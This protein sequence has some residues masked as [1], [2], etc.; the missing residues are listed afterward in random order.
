[1]RQ[2]IEA[3]VTS[4]ET[5]GMTRRQLVGNLAALVGL[6][7]GGAGGLLAQSPAEKSTF[8]AFGVHHLA[9]KVTDLD[10][11]Q[12]FYERHLGL[13]PM[14]LPGVPPF[15]RFMACPSPSDCWSQTHV[16]NLWKAE[17]PGLH[18]VCFAVSD[19]DQKSAVEKLWAENLS[20]EQRGNSAYFRDPDGL[21]IQVGGRDAD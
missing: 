2:Q 12:S 1:M 17:A 8:E 13:K 21:T 3:L 14:A 18:H 11:S 9:L 16:L 7:A 10:R 4:F 20:P 19:Y 15:M 6:A 5:G